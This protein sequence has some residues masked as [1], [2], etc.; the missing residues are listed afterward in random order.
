MRTIEYALFSYCNSNSV[1]SQ[2]ILTKYANT[3]IIQN[4]K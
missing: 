4:V 3:E 1:K 2:N